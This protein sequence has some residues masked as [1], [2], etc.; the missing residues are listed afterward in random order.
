MKLLLIH[1]DYLEY[2]A[3]K[4]T[5]MAEDIPEEKMSG[6]AE[7]T[8]VAFFTVEK[9]DEGKVNAVASK[10]VDAI[11]ETAEKVQTDSISLYPYAHLS[12]SLSDPETGKA[13]AAEME[14]LLLD[15]GFEV[16]RSP[17]GWYKS[18]KISCKGHPLSELSREIRVTGEGQA[19]DAEL[20]DAVK[21]EEKAESKWFVLDLDGGLHPLTLENNSVK[22]YKF[23]ERKGLK[24]FSQYEMAKSRAAKKEPPHVALMQRLELV[25]YE[26]GSDPGH[27]RYF[28]KGRMVKSLLE[29]YVTTRVKE[30]GGMEIETPIMYDF[31]HPSLKKYLHRF[32]ARQYAIQTPDK[33]VFLRFAAC[34][35][36][37]L[38]LHDA[39]ISYKHL[40]IRLYE[41]TKY[42]FRV[43]Q[44]GELAGL[45]RLRAFTMPDCHSFCADLDMAKAE[46]E[47][48][49][50]LSR[51]LISGVGFDVPNELE[52]AIRVTKEFWEQNREF[53]T[54]LVR[55]WGKPALVEMWEG[56]FFYFVFKYEW[57]FVD[58]LGKAS[59]LNTDQIDVENAERYG[60]TYVGADGQQHH[61]LILHQSPSGGIERVMYAMLEKQH[62]VQQRGEKP[63]LP[64]WL[65]PT[66]LRLIPVTE[67]FTE[68]CRK[69]A[70]SLPFRVDVDDR[71]GKVGRKIRDAE[72]EWVPFILVY[73]E[74]EKGSDTLPVR[75]RATGQVEEFTLER[76]TEK[77]KQEQGNYPFESL[78]LPM[79]LSKRPIFR[80]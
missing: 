75:V 62:M 36:Q 9:E 17:F 1:S 71:G 7:E 78:P 4:A 65:T 38:M 80:G 40:P 13:A 39:T 24:A 43:E 47:D 77:L 74:K 60:I 2:E 14:R 73:G 26:P 52:F 5:K 56:R 50:E 58:A 41:M 46:L 70:T 29:R 31:E 20:S 33:R 19:G 61:P 30:T 32:P 34:F 16:L 72:K 3:K 21:A 27:F 12:A 37:F 6:R 22:G 55:R 48:R 57:N 15:K 64:F 68:D 69:L 18:F 42:S 8:L 23:G 66:Q 76:L 79:M 54:G 45:R 35:G 25:D 63:M 67:D 10:A 59:A 28:P 49:F 51:E 44:R 11:A 53:I